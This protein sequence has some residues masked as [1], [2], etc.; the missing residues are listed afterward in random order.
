MRTQVWLK[1][2]KESY[3]AERQRKL[4]LH[5]QPQICDKSNVKWKLEDYFRGR[6]TNH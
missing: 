5:L 2:E 3:L 1:L 6:F 4:I